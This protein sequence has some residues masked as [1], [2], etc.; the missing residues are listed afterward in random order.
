MGNVGRGIWGHV[1]TAPSAR[2]GS[3][4]Q[5]STGVDHRSDRR[6]SRYETERTARSPRRYA[7]GSASAASTPLDQSPFKESIQQ[8]KP[9][10]LYRQQ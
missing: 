6:I 1:T 5:R 2:A 3:Q 4:E 10:V 8:L 7:P 9:K